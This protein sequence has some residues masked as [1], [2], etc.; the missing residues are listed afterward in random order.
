MHG[1]PRKTLTTSTKKTGQTWKGIIPCGLKDWTKKADQV[2]QARLHFL[3]IKNSF[4]FFLF[5]LLVLYH[6]VGAFDLRKAVLAGK[7][8]RV[9]KW[10]FK[11]LDEAREKVRQEVLKGRNIT[12]F[13]Y[14]VNVQGASLATNV[15]S[16]GLPIFTEFSTGFIGHFPQMSDLI[17]LINS[18]LPLG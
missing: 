6:D 5:F 8:K 11:N 16:Q 10:F 7:G 14:F 4:I 17:W 1:G 9:V 3:K 2:S 13:N 15:N 12:R 18:K